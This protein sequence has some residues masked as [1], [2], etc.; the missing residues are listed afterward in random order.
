MELEKNVVVSGKKADYMKLLNS[1]SLH[2][3]H[4]CTH[5]D[6]RISETSAILIIH[7]FNAKEHFSIETEFLSL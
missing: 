2:I 5:F 7:S 3:S 4:K 6:N 1:S